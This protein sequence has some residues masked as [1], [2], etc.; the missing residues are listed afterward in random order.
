MRQLEQSVA[1]GS[2]EVS[3]I[4]W[5]QL[6]R[7]ILKEIGRDIT[8]DIPHASAVAVGRCNGKTPQDVAGL[9]GLSPDTISSCLVGV[10]LW[11]QA[12]LRPCRVFLMLCHED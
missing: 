2:E 12:M 5:E 1:A 6:H 7:Q 8:L 3:Q 4:H 9:A 10:K 11:P